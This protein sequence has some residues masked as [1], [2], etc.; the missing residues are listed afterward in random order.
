MPL[1][2]R[3]LTPQLSVG[4]GVGEAVGFGV[5]DGVGDGEGIGVGDG[6]GDGV[7]AAVVGDG[8]GNGVGE[9]VG[10]HVTNSVGND[11]VNWQVT[12]SMAVKYDG[13]TPPGA[14]VNKTF[15]PRTVPSGQA[16]PFCTVIFTPFGITSHCGGVTIGDHSAM[17]AQPKLPCCHARAL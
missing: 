11:H 9:G 16:S 6:D 17:V 4:T 8:D 12:S 1:G 15:K 3:T 10:P 5:G 2:K 14:Q 13:P 7:G